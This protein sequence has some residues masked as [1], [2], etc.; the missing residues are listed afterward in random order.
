[1]RFTPLFG[2]ICENFKGIEM[3]KKTI[4]SAIIVSAFATTAYADEARPE[5]F[6]TFVSGD[7]GHTQYSP[8]GLPNINS[9]DFNLRA[10]A[11]YIAP[12][13]FGGQVDGVYSKRSLDRV[14]V[15]T[16]DLAGHLFY[17]NEKFLIGGF[18]QYRNPDF[19]YKSDV[20]GDQFVVNYLADSLISEQVFWG[21]E[22][23][24]FL[25]D[26]TVYGQAGKQTF[27]NQ[28]DISGQKILDDGYFANI[29]ARYFIKDNWKIDVGYAYSKSNL[30]SGGFEGEN[31]ANQYTL[32]LA[33]EYR[34][35]DSPVSLYALY[36]HS[37]AKYNASQSSSLSG[38]NVD[39]DQLFAGIKVNFG[40]NS[41]KSRDRSGAS[42]DPLSQTPTAAVLLGS[43]VAN[44]S[45][46][47]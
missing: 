21:A 20:S 37:Q 8:D 3:F 29:K 13:N 27:V 28:H 46:F 1:M 12:N 32:S 11:S 15:S 10:S 38:L 30:N 9:T 34:L 19:K 31:S 33:T 47:R 40:S 23:Q 41:L 5:A 22:G 6:D 14:D 17:R 36:N 39:S 43:A 35:T 18:A 16:V 26:V 45:I 7:I 25:G 44:G 24:V 4:I 2:I 42:L